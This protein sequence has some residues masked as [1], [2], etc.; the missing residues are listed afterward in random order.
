MV[1]KLSDFL[2]TSFSTLSAN[3]TNSTGITYPG[4]VVHTTTSLPGVGIGT[5]LQYT[6]E[7]SNNNN[8][9]GMTLETVTTDVTAGSEDFDFVVRLMQNGG[10]ADQRFRVSS[11][12]NVTISGGIFANGS[13]GTAGQVLTS[14]GAGIFWGTTSNAA[15]RAIAMSIVFG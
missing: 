8:E 1:V 5:G 3:D 10:P 11:T 6:V 13:I 12:G 2:N 15:S 14:N 4:S 9:I 7:T